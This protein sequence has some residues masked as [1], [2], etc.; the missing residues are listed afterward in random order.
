LTCSRPFFESHPLAPSS[1]I[2]R[3]RGLLTIA[4]VGY[5][6]RLEQLEQCLTRQNGSAPCLITAAD[7][8]ALCPTLRVEKIDGALYEPDALDL[9]VGAL[10]QRFLSGLSE[11]GSA[12]VHSATVHGIF[13]RNNTWRVLT[14]GTNFSARILVNAA[15]AWCDEVAKAASIRPVGI[16][17]TRRTA[18]A[19]TLT[20]GDMAAHWPAVVDVLGTYSFKPDASRI[21]VAPAD[22][23][24]L[25]ACEAEPDDLEIAMAAAQIADV[26]EI[27]VTSIRAAW[28]GLNSR[29]SHGVPVLGSALEEPS[30]FWLAG[31]SNLGISGSPALGQVIAFLV[32]RGELPPIF[33]ALRVNSSDFHPNRKS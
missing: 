27:P 29:I 5:G 4:P 14:A 26:S 15:G 24:P 10:R 19:L 9:D 3:P 28:A 23:I 31:E 22:G 11:K 25:P 20:N 18:F 33:R 21:V 13:R 30:F 1:P 2:V 32:V 12:V 6:S 17:S 7:A 8:H 16:A